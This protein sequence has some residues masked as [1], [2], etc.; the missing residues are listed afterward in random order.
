MYPSLD[1]QVDFCLSHQWIYTFLHAT[2]S[3][4][5]VL[6]LEIF[7]TSTCLYSVGGSQRREL[8]LTSDPAFV[9][10]SVFC[11]MGGER[12]SPQATERC[13]FVPTPLHSQA[14]K[15]ATDALGR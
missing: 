9:G 3:E 1:H 4:A 14:L 12:E 10:M 6:L 7:Y 2:R 5:L 13:L 11:A 15:C 8:K